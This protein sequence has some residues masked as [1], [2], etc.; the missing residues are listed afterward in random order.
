MNFLAHCLIGAR[1]AEPIEQPGLV[2]GGFLGDFVKGPVPDAMPGELALGV[3]LHR[4]LDAYS[5]HQP[6]IRAS[7]DRFPSDLRRLAPIFVDIICDHLLT[8]RWS[9]WHP[10]PLEGFTARIYDHVDA[11]AAWLS[12]DGARFLAYARDRDLLSGYGNWQLTVRAMHSVTRRL[13][14][15]ELDVDLDRQ[16]AGLLDGLENDF[17]TYFPDLI[18]HARNYVAGAVD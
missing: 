4:R 16:V 6:A 11:H 8:R 14:R 3:R 5:A 17:I 2:A 13:G 18:E 9:E 15:Q 12:P 7:C 1:A 10:E